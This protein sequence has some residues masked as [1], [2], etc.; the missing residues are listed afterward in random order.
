M[1]CWCGNTDLVD[2]DAGYRRCDNCQ[3]LVSIKTAAKF[4]PKVTDDSADFYGK[5]YWF[6][7]QTRD[8]GTPDIIE[9]SRTDLADRAAYWMRSLLRFAL[10]PSKVLEIGCGHGGFV[11][12]M[13]QAGFHATGLEL[14]PSIVELAK[15]TFGIDV[16]TGP[17]ESQP[18]PAGTYDAVVILDVIEHLPDPVGTL[19]KCLEILTPT[20]VLFGQTPAYPAN[21]SVAELTSTGHEFPQMLDPAEHLFLFSEPAIERLF[22]QIGAASIR[23]VPAVFG[24]YDQSFFLSRAPLVETTEV[25]RNAA[26]EKSVAGRFIR[27]MLDIDQRRL[28]LLEKYRAA[29]N[30]K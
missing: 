3:T 25:A 4:D 27:A 30:A 19:S 1:R 6:D 13:N 24:F 7:H 29:V 2:F 9:R 26:L 20:G 8:L 17:I 12:M 11:A 23:F 10:P 5:N 16:L 21:Q 28:D 22:R 18:I 14:S 15:K